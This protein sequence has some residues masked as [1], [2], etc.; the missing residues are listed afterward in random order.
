MTFDRFLWFSYMTI[1]MKLLIRFDL[2]VLLRLLYR[3]ATTEGSQP[4][5]PKIFNTFPSTCKEVRGTTRTFTQTHTYIFFSSLFLN[6]P[7]TLSRH[8]LR[9]SPY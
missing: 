7:N 8:N 9:S 2:P 5:N 6:R 3:K 1:T 4:R